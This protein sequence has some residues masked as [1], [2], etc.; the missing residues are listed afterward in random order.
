MYID[1]DYDK[2][3]NN[4]EFEDTRKNDYL[5]PYKIYQATNVTL[6]IPKG[7]VVAELPKGIAE[8]HP[9]FSFSVS[10]KQKGNK[11]NY[12]NIKLKNKH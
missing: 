7:Y 8:T 12:K 6:D 1:L 4:F 3:F 11:I 5:F 9:D 10:F 2:A